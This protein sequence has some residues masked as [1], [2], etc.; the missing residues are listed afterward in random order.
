MPVGNAGE[1]GAVGSIAPQ[2]VERAAAAQV[3]NQ[4]GGFAFANFRIVGQ[5]DGGWD[6]EAHR[7]PQGH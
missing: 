6:V 5:V 2:N 7:L 1:Q 4:C 3:E